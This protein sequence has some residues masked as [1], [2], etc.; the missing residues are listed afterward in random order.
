MPDYDVVIVGAGP[1]GLSAG[2]Y[3][4]RGKYRTLAIDKESFGGQIT[5]VEWIENYPGFS[6]GVAGPHLAS[7]MLTQAAGFGLQLEL[8]E[9]SGI[10][11][12]S[13]S[14]C[15]QLT[16]GRS[17][18]AKAIIIASGCRRMKLGV[19]GE[20]KFEGRGV[21]G[22]ALCDGD[23]FS[24]KIVAVCGGGDTGLTEALYMT[25]LASHVVLLAQLVWARS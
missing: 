1:A 17:L 4:T 23:Q 2:L 22:C 20:N 6:H 7:E 10:E 15:L 24:G 19:P 21:F 12:Y 5:K 13:R 16:D 11:L 14:R 9:V 25:K 8:G 3:L 18:T